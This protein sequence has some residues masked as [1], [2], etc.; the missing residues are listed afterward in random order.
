MP[1]SLQPCG[2]SPARLLCP[3]GSPGKNTGMS[4]HALLQRVFLTQGSNSFLL[5]LLHLQA[6][7]LP[8]VPPGKPESCYSN[9]NNN[10]NSKSWLLPCPGYDKQCC[11][12]HWGARV[13]FRS[14]ILGVYAQKWDCW[15]IWKFYFQFFKRSP[16]SY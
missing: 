9:N 10:K 1:D 16:K 5:C 3:W 14:G 6:G 7:S 2:P 13:S 11:D 4:S 8:Q 15:L 12:E